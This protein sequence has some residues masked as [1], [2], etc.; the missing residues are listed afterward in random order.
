MEKQTEINHIPISM[1]VLLSNLYA[2]CMV[3]FM[4]ARRIFSMGGQ[5]V[6]PA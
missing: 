2:N 3:Y 5:M 4:G 1:P 6:N